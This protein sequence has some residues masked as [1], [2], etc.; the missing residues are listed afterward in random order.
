MTREDVPW[1]LKHILLIVVGWVVAL[2]LFSMVAVNRFNIEKDTAYPWIIGGMAVEHKAWNPLTYLYRW[3]SYWYMNIATEGYS[4]NP[5]V[6]GLYNVVFF[7]LYPLLL[8]CVSKILFLPM[9]AAGVLVSIISL[10]GACWFLY[11]L[12]AEQFPRVHAKRVVLSLLIFPTAIFLTA[13]YTEALFLFLSVASFYYARKKRW[14]MAGLFG[15]LAA[16]TRIN[17]I[18]LFLP[19]LYSYLTTEKNNPDRPSI[20]SIFLVPLGT[21]LY[22]LYLRIS[23]GDFLLFFKAESMWGRVV[24]SNNFISS[25]CCFSED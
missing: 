24:G 2:S 8:A 22:F 19:L 5:A 12:V 6:P 9:I 20:A 3:D 23:F 21:C 11:R 13:V 1:R 16:L 4:F 17:G 7:P 15:G 14:W 18:I 25:L 10:V